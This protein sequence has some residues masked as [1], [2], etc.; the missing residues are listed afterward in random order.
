MTELISDRSVDKKTKQNKAKQNPRALP[1]FIDRLFL[2]FAN[3]EC[4]YYIISNAPSP[5]N[6]QTLS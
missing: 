1:H 3:W 2:N 4:T 5:N 6:N